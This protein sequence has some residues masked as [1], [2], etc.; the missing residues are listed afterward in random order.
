MLQRTQQKGFML[1][2]ARALIATG[3]S[4]C[5]VP[6]ESSTLTEL[7]TTADGG[8]GERILWSGFVPYD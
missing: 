2:G 7:T 5:V 4:L 8:S 3:E 1:V 6:A